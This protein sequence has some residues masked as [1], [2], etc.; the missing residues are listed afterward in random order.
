MTGLRHGETVEGAQSLVLDT[1]EPPLVAD[2]DLADPQ[3]AASDGGLDQLVAT[4][5]I[6]I[7]CR[8]TSTQQQQQQGTGA[9]VLSLE[10]G[11]TAEQGIKSSL[12]AQ[13]HDL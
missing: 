9:H 4:T 3:L 8:S 5:L 12:T 10:Q 6:T 7:S 11:K 13:S 1:L 2:L